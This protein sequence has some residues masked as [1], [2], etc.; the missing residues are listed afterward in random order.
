MVGAGH[1]F[2]ER[3]SDKIVGKDGLLSGYRINGTDYHFGTEGMIF[4]LAYSLSL[5]VSRMQCP[6]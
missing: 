1:Y 4:L 2:F 3:W 6:A 5:L